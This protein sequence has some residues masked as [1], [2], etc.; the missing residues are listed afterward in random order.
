MDIVEVVIRIGVA[1]AI[2]Y[3]GTGVVAVLVVLAINF[4]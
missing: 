4:L 1:I 3:I 2:G